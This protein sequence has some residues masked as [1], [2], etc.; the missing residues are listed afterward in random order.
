MARNRWIPVLV[1]LALVLGGCGGAD[2]PSQTHSY[3]VMLADCRTGESVLTPYAYFG[4]LAPKNL[5]DALGQQLQLDLAVVAAT[6]SEDGVVRVTF[7][8]DNAFAHCVEATGLYG[9]LDS[10]LQTLRGAYGQSKRFYPL[11]QGGEER[12]GVVLNGTAEYIPAQERLPEPEDGDL[13]AQDAITYAVNLTYGEF[14]DREGLVLGGNVQSAITMEN[15]K[16][17]YDVRVYSLSDPDSTL[18]RF[19]IA[20]DGLSVYGYDANTGAFS[21]EYY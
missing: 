1:L 2:V 20:Y 5:L 18:R 16:R 15:G 3:T 4:N 13:T 6:V 12:F 7:G 11:W 10:V 17:Y 21:K 14:P 8:A 9:L 19:A